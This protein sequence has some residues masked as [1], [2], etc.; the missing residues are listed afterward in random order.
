MKSKLIKAIMGYG[1]GYILG[2]LVCGLSWQIS[3]VLFLAS[4]GGHILGMLAMKEELNN[5]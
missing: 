2:Y 1:I 5:G 3:V 4:V